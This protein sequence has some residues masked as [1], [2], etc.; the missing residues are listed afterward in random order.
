MG[1]FAAVFERL[2]LGENASARDA[3]ALRDA[4]AGA[5]AGG[6]D[7]LRSSFGRFLSRAS[8]SKASEA[9]SFGDASRWSFDASLEFFLLD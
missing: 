8:L 1:V 4:D 9:A 7:A 5:G 2:A 6:M 3:E